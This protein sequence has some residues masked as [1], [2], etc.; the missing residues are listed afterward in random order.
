[1][2]R[3]LAFIPLLSLLVLTG[4]GC[5]VFGGAKTIGTAD[6]GVYRTGNAGD[7]WVQAVALPTAKGVGTL[8]GA[9]VVAL[10]AD[11]Q[12]PLVFYAGTRENGLAY[13]VDAGA[14]WQRPRLEA[15]RDGLIADV[16]VDPRATCTAYVV[17][18]QRLFKTADCARSFDQDVFVETRANV[19]ISD[20]ALDW[21]NPKVLWMG[22]T[23]G[24]VQK[25]E[26]GGKTWRRALDNKSGVTSVLVGASDSRVVI[27]GT[28]GGGF[29][30]TA[31]AG[32][33]W[34]QA[35]EELKKMRGADTVLALAQDAKGK[36]VV[37]ATEYGL[38]RS[39]DA[40]ATWEPLQLLTAAG[41]VQ[42]R[43]LAVGPEK[44]D[45]IAYAVGGTFY[46]SV[47]G[48]KNWTTHKLPSTREPLRLLPDLS[49]ADAYFL[50]FAAPMKK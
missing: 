10:E 25:S 14:S 21:Y 42:I 27:V 45:A 3:S 13:T 2:R 4:Q 11:P 9:N 49:S 6:G 15:L 48:G 7:S 43:A 32:A 17:K 50:G 1:M 41:Q 44:P 22:E 33:S 36:A 37:A 28:K 12:D 16:E 19:Q 34:T 31:D 24:D 40:G 38:L 23:N 30:R 20:L 35:K 29:Y 5:T 26:D 47:D 46:R 39:V 8:A 18:G